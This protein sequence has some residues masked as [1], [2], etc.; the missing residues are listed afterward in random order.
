[1]HV[2]IIIIIASKFV[3]DSQ[4]DYVHNL[5]PSFLFHAD[6]GFARQQDFRGVSTPCGSF[7][8]AAPELFSGK[9][10][11]TYDF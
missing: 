11:S 4:Q 2:A 1:M 8:Y 10:G 7:S 5:F 6:F 3:Y 9:P